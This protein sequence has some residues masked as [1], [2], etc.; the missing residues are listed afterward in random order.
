MQVSMERTSHIWLSML[1]VLYGRA[2]QAFG[3][4]HVIVP[5]ASWNAIYYSSTDDLSCSS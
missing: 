3:K 1:N 4:E 5:V 2:S